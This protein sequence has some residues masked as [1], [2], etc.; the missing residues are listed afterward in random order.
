MARA[1]GKGHLYQRGKYYHL[2]YKINGKRIRRS[3]GVTTKPK[4]EIEAK[5]ILDLINFKKEKSYIEKAGIY[6][7]ADEIERRQISVTT[8]SLDD[9]WAKYEPYTANL[10]D[11]TKEDYKSALS[12]LIKWIKTSKKNITQLSEIDD[13]IAVEYQDHL[14]RINK[15]GRTINRHTQALSRIIKVLN[16]K[17]GYHLPN[18]WRSL[19][20]KPK[21]TV[22]KKPFSEKEV[23]NLLDLF[24]RPDLIDI[25]NLKEWELVFNLGAYTGLRFKD[26]ICVKWE[27]IDFKSNII[28][29]IPAKTKRLNKEIE[30]PIHQELLKKLEIAKSWENDSS[31][32]CSVLA[33]EYLIK[34]RPLVNIST[35]I[36]EKSGIK[37]RK[38]F[39]N[40]EKSNCVYGFHSL[41]YSF[42]TNCA[43]NGI[44]LET[45]QDLVGHASREMTAHYLKV[46]NEQK[47]VAIDS[48]D[49]SIQTLP[50][51]DKIS[52]IEVSPIE[53]AIKVLEGAN[54]QTWERSRKEAIRLLKG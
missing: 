51:L 12:F 52:Q 18:P 16:I 44:P 36:I 1:K 8:I 50:K 42:V 28:T 40:R 15:S 43:K 22:S 21:N 25:S 45:M 39:E 46:S 48:I 23:K 32:I 27:F 3:L 30:I 37:V 7:D 53:Q 4:A 13:I 6:L 29:I 31:Y 9:A 5:K 47:R 17:K 19:D 41:R 54:G 10:A 49:Y 33:N 2:E 34:G 38:K 20:L 24:N 14:E 35:M 26:C 11:S